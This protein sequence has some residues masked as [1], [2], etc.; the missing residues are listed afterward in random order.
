MQQGHLPKF[1]DAHRAETKSGLETHQLFGHGILY[2]IPDEKMDEFYRLYCNYVANNGPLTITEKMTRIGPLRVD[3]DFLYDGHVEDHKHTRAMTISFVKAYMAEAARYV[4]I[5]EITDVFVMEK[6]EPTFYPG[7]KE[8]KSGIHLVVPEVRVNRNIELAIRNTLLPK[9][10]EFFP[11]LDL[12]KDW[13]ETYDKSPLNHTSWWALLGSK[14]PAGEGATP[15]PYQLKY[16]IEWDPNDVNI[17]ID[18]EV[19]REVKPENV[20]KFSI[21]SPSNSETPFTE[22]GQAYALREEEVRIS[23][24]AAVVPQRGRPAQRNGDPG[25]RGSSPTRTIYLQPLSESMLKYYEGHVFNLNAERYN[26]HDERTNVGHCLKNIHPELDTLWLEFCSQRQD[27]KYDPREAMA[28]WQGFNFRNDGAKLGIGSLRHWSRTDDPVGYLEIEKR[29]IDR[30]LDEA[31][32]TQTEHDMAQVVYAKFRDEFKCARFS[33]SAWYWFAGHTWRETDKG[34]SLQC[35]LSSDVFKDFFRKETEISNMMN[36]DGF[37]QCPEGKHEPNGCDW[38]KADKK[39]QAYAHMRKQL[40]T[41]RFKENVMKE[42]RELFLDEDFATK[43][44]E[45]KNL[46]AFANG[47]FDTLTFEFR[48]GKPEDYISFCTNLEYHPDRPHDSYP[49]W[50]ELNKF[51]NDVL[52]DPDVREYFLSYLA[53]SLS[54]NN[55]AQKFHIL[56]GSGS[57]GKSMLMNLT[58]TAMGDYACKAPISLLTQARNK[59]AAAAPELVRMKG[60]RFVTMQEP[61]EQVPLNTGLMKELAS[62]EKITARDLYAGSK[63]MLDFD[64]QA[65]FNLACNEKPKINTQ[66]GGT[67]RRLVVINFL[68]KFVSDPRLPNEKPIDE[69]IVQKSQSKEWAEAFLSYLVFLYTKG[70]GFRKLTPP[71]KVME[72][73]SEYKEDSDVIAKFLHEKIHV[74]PPLAEDEQPREP[75]SWTSITSSF[76]EWKRTNEFIGK[77]TA[78]ELKKRIEASHG[79]LPRGGWTS[80]RCGDA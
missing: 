10:D 4:Q 43:V 48:D 73:T 37:P 24:G 25:S 50:A 17:A 59:S 74:H 77:G 46:I 31:T 45:N 67:W 78:A 56:T 55:E 42:S 2:S 68:S 57:N 61:D 70:K 63:Q 54:G 21:R 3:L 72:Y 29:N 58:S 65:R 33:A 52:P 34:V 80:F 13:R 76:S 8:S 15:Q 75:T 32:D 14:K 30:L 19:N 9:M 23:G 12:K 38:C 20:R 64:L 16:S 66:D 22:M 71:E 60:R 44:D 27:G 26:S 1:L 51:L 11:G 79:K 28:K 7:K 41:T 36:T 40:R 49:C 18:E 53:T 39:R 62:S 5:P 35:R 47:V 69:S 6:P